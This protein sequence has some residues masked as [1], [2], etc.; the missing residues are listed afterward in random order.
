MI[1]PN[2][3]LCFIMKFYKTKI[4]KKFMDGNTAYM[5]IKTDGTKLSFLHFFFTKLHS[6]N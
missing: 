2:Y 3:F 5:I 4:T 1:Q 6:Q